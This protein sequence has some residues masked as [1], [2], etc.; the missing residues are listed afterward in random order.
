MTG[1]G[2]Q[3]SYQSFGKVQWEFRNSVCNSDRFPDL[4]VDSGGQRFSTDQLLDATDLLH[5][6][7]E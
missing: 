1:H 6:R 2:Q 3:F 7:S 5:A 4:K